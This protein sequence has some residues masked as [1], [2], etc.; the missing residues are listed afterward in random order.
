M[1]NRIGAKEAG[2]VEKVTNNRGK[3]KSD[4][5]K[6]SL[7]EAIRVPHALEEANG[8]KPLPPL[9]TANALGMSPGSSDFRQILSCSIKYGLTSGSYNQERVSLEEFGRNIVEPKSE[10]EKKA[11]LLAAAMRPETFRDIYNHYRGKKLPDIEFFKNT[12]VREFQVPREH[13]EKCVSVFNSNMEYVGL[14][15]MATTGRWLSM[16]Q[17]PEFVSKESN[18]KEAPKEISENDSGTIE[19]SAGLVKT[20]VSAL[21]PKKNAIFLGHGK[22]RKPLEQLKQILDQY[23]IPYLVAVQE[24]NRF[25][26]ISQKVADIMSECGAAILLFTADEELKGVDGTAIFRP[27][28]NVVYE[29]GAASVLYGGKIIIFKEETV[30]FPTNFKDIG[31][32]AFEKD[33]LGAKTNELFSE[34]IAFGLIKVTVGS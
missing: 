19:S 7:E 18:S 30:S 26:P 27:S 14:V 9:E 12:V 15:K 16:E 20:D 24:A 13:A 3:V 11:A 8:G 1:K 29:L 4:F 22:N 10:A 33:D 23:K 2:K 21:P 17:L 32:I 31:Y 5:P 25:R 6:H 34:L 28:E